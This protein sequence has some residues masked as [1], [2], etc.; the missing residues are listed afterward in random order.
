MCIEIGA[1]DHNSFKEEGTTT[2]GVSSSSRPS[3]NC[4]VPRT[5]AAYEDG[6]GT[7][8]AQQCDIAEFL[9]LDSTREADAVVKSHRDKIDSINTDLSGDTSHDDDDD[10]FFFFDEDDEEEGDDDSLHK[11]NYI[12]NSTLER[13]DVP[14]Q[15]TIATLLS[16]SLSDSD[17]GVESYSQPKIGTLLLK[18]S[19]E[20]TKNTKKINKKSIL[21]KISNVKRSVVSLGLF[22]SRPSSSIPK[23][24]ATASMIDRGGQNHPQ[25]PKAKLAFSS[26]ADGSPQVSPLKEFQHDGSKKP[27]QS[28]LKKATSMIDL[29]PKLAPGN[30]PA[31]SM[32]PNI[33]FSTLEIREYNITIG[34]NP[35]GCQGP[36][37]SLDWNYCP[38]STV[39]M[40]IET[41]EEHRGQRRAKHE[42]YMPA[43]IRMWTL[44]ENLGYSMIEIMD[45]SKAAESIRKDR[46]KSIKNK[47]IYDLQ[48]KVGKLLGRD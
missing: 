17:A 4:S 45:A 21:R 27:A 35:G 38:D 42:M 29:S 19:G 46:A 41:Y 47:K 24:K 1:A 28:I 5:S 20:K 3:K 12:D 34:D 30:K 8:K 31:S 48:Y 44:T 10:G 6:L 18:P 26:D 43:S 33:S 9:F 2:N 39:K 36:P 14:L 22:H 7:E 23:R 25:L 32:K 11:R 37:I 15:N 13:K 40:C 16:K